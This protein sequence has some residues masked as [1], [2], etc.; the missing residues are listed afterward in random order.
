MTDGPDN[1]RRG[2]GRLKEIWRME[3]MGDIL[4]KGPIAWTGKNWKTN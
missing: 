3:R 4:G 2:G 1:I